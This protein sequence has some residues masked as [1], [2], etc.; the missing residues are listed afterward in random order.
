MTFYDITPPITPDLRV[1]PGDTTPQR[2]VLLDMRRGDDL[3]LL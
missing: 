2:E 1:W 3:T